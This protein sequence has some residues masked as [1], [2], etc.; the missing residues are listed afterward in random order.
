MVETSSKL[1]Q[2][3]V[4]HQRLK[5]KAH[6]FAYDVYM[7][8]LDLAELNTLTKFRLFSHNRF[9]LFAFYDQD[10]LK[11]FGQ[12]TLFERFK[13]LLKSRQVIADVVSVRLLT[14][15]RIL[16]YVFNPVSF[17]FGFDKNDIAVV[18][19]AEVSNTFGEMKIYMLEETE[20]GL[21]K[22][23]VPKEFYVSPYVKLLDRFDFVVPV[24]GKTLK[25]CVD[26]L[27]GLDSSKVLVSSIKGQSQEFGDKQL[28]RLFLL[29]PLVTLK[30]ISMIHFQAFLLYLKGIPF[31][32][33]E[34]KIESQTEILNVQKVN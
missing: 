7:F 5:P 13:Q 34:E 26:T 24:P 9:N 31:Y 17:Y 1:Y 21:F 19:V 15:P 10:H 16:G 23:N 2:C 28:L 11:G 20:P 32:K 14:Y 27:D 22:I 33:K 18:G 29:Y 25:I 4:R 6:R 8:Y 3:Q 12:G 30:V